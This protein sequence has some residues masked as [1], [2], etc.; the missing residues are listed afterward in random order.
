[1]DIVAHDV[2]LIP[3]ATDF[4]HAHNV[5]MLKLS[6]GSCL[7]QKLLVLLRTQLML[8][9][10]LDRYQSVKLGVLS[11]PDRAECPCSKLFDEFEVADSLADGVERKRFFLDQTEATAARWT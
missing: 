2:D 4:M 10:H 8:G 7:A 6:S 5:R 9:R 1:M 11:L 3:F